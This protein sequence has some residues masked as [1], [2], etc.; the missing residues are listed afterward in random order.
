VLSSHG[1]L[2]LQTDEV[3][4]T[5]F[6]I[7]RIR[8]YA[9][10]QTIYA[11]GEPANGVYGLVDGG[12]DI[13]IPVADNPPV[14]IYRADPGFWVGDL[15]TLAGK[16]RLVS[17]R[18]NT[19]TTMCVLPGRDLVS[20]LERQPALYRPLYALMHENMRLTFE[21][22]G[23]LLS[24]SAVERVARRLSLAARGRRDDGDPWID[25]PQ[26][27][28]SIMLG[29]S[30]ASVHRAIRRLSKLGLIETGYGRIRV[31]DPDALGRFREHPDDGA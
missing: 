6:S 26:N 12:L 9:A 29:L 16:D 18:A 5:F 15:A 23:D 21:L 4:S 20:L 25:L 13:V 10:G 1:W 11:A 8:S 28:L 3:R 19:P 14:L 7:A 22:M 24:F 17:L 30:S 27:T 31:V 2:A